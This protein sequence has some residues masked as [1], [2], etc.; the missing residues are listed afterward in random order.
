MC[1]LKIYNGRGKQK[2][3]SL[4]IKYITYLDFLILF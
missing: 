3:C 2:I 4:K 1:V